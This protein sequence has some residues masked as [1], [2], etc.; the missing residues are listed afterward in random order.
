MLL[1]S[2]RM[3]QTSSSKTRPCFSFITAAAEPCN[4]VAMGRIFVM[5]GI[6]DYKRGEF[7]S[8]LGG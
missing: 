5:L 4:F 7:I 6:A 8:M 1:D 3:L 2:N